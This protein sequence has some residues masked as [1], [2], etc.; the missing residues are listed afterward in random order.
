MDNKYLLTSE[1][2]W[3]YITESGTRVQNLL[4]AQ[5]DK[6][7]RAGWKSPEDVVKVGCPD[8]QKC[9]CFQAREKAI[10]QAREEALREVH[11]NYLK[12]WP[13]PKFLEWLHAAL[14]SGRMPWKEG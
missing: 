10:S 4:R 2:S 11:D 3:Q 13:P 5:A 7:I 6:M 12:M 9:I 1:E 8:Y 14:K